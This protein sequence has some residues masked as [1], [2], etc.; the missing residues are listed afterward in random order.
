C[1]CEEVA[2]IEC[3]VTMKL[4]RRT[5][6]V[7]RSGIQDHVYL[8]A[9]IA[10]ERCIVGAGQHLKLTDGIDGRPHTERVQL[11]IDVVDTIEQEVVR[12]F[13]RAVNTEREIAANRTS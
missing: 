6:K 1:G 5:V 13:A 10:T 12:I 9:G 7:V 4:K 8:C 3:G 2:R 11:R